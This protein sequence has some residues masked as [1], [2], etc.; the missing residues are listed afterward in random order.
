MHAKVSMVIA[1]YNKVEWIGEM[2]DSVLAQKWN[3]IE[4]ILVNDGSTDGTREIISVYEKKFLSRGYEV[5]IIDQINQGVAVAVRNGLIRISG[6]Y[7]CIP[8]CDDWIHS[9]YISSMATLLEENPNEVWVRCDSIKSSSHRTDKPY[10]SKK[11]YEE[12]SCYYFEKYPYK[13]VESFMLRRIFWGVVYNLFRVDYIK[14]CGIIEKFITCT[15]VSQEPQVLFPL[16]LSNKKPIFLHKKLYD[17]RRRDDSILRS[18][19]KT[20]ES[21][22]EF[23][24]NYMNLVKA[25]LAAHGKLNS[26]TMSLISL[27]EIIFYRD[28]ILL[29]MQEKDDIEILIDMVNILNNSS[30]LKSK[31]KIDDARKMETG[32]FYKCISDFLIGYPAKEI[33]IKKKD[34]GRI[35]A[36]AAYGKKLNSIINGLLNSDIRPDVFWDILAKPD[37]QIDGIPVA[38]PLFES[39]TQND[40][41]LLFLG[42]KNA[43]SMINIFKQTP[44]AKNIWLYED[45]YEYIALYYIDVLDL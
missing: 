13:L 34:N 41:I 14:E 1:C 15:N 23:V 39:L 42:G 11:M 43:E 33:E 10:T 22:K 37:D 28:L 36:Y 9:E 19:I 20:P 7:V 32:L 26:Y 40:T 17:Y 21:I 3:N 44:A 31:I 2:F 27:S 18:I 16:I 12:T 45:I 5:V 8:D 25:T 6:K 24:S 29:E 30:L 38:R 35:I 4:L